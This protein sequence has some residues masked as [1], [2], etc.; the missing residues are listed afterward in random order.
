MFTG[1]VEEL[2]IVT[3]LVRAASAGK[4]IASVSKNL[5]AAKIGDSIAVNGVC[6]TVTNIRRNF[7]EFD[8]SAATLKYS[9]LADLKVGDRVHLEQALQFSSRLGGHL[10]SGHVDGTGEIRQK[11]NRGSDFDLFISIPSDLLCYLVPKGSIAVDGVSLT[12][13]DVQQGLI[14]VTIVPHTAK[15]TMLDGKNVGDRVNIE[16]DMLSK[17]IERH[18]RQELS[19]PN[20]SPMPMLGY[21]PMGWIDN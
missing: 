8:L 21:L 9:A 18:L 19:P 2:G 13:V 16:V 10:V 17:Y 5:T 6:L 20:E 12:V 7:I 4:L 11:V 1:L 3:S 15:T 14:V